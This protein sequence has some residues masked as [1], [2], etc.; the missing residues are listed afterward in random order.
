MAVFSRDRMARGVK[1]LREHVFSPMTSIATALSNKGIGIENLEQPRAP[2]RMDIWIPS[3]SLKYLWDI[4]AG[5]TSTGLERGT[6]HFAVPI[7]LLPL[8]EE[9]NH[10]GTLV[11]A[12]SLPVLEEVMLS[13]DQGAEPGFFKPGL[14]TYEPERGPSNAEITLSILSKTP[15]WLDDDAG[16]DPDAELFSATLPPEA[17]FGEALRFNPQVWDGL[18]IPHN[19]YKTLLVALSADTLGQVF[20]ETRQ[21]YELPSLLISLR[22]SHRLV[23]H[24]ENLQNQADAGATTADTVTVTVPAGNTAIE[25]DGADGVQ[26]NADI[27]DVKLLER[28][29]G[30]QQADGRRPVK[31]HIADD[32]VYHVVV[33]PMLHQTTAWGVRPSVLAYGG[34]NT[35]GLVEGVGWIEEQ[36]IPITWPWEIHHVSA[37]FNYGAPRRAGWQQLTGLGAD[38]KGV[39]P[40][41]ADL[42]VDIGVGLFTGV[43]ADH[44]AWQQV[45]RMNIAFNSLS[46]NTFDRV[47]VTNR[48][49]MT[50]EGFQFELVTIP[51]VGVDGISPKN[52]LGGGGSQGKP[53]QVGR[54]TTR[55]SSRSNID[56]GAPA[57]RG[58]E[59]FL[60]CRWRWWDALG[61][62]LDNVKYTKNGILSGVGGNFLVICGKKPL[63][64]EDGVPGNM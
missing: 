10:T 30:G 5:W 54:G 51:L 52:V 47:R 31:T 26:T 24:G 1:L 13:F 8:Q 41:H 48:Q 6:R 16:W 53:I 17:F 23:P 61:D 29:G 60:C 46:G 34:A 56:G 63:V 64:G 14:G 33:L 38:I 49:D 25:A 22:F 21:D 57:T 62:P 40:T 3:A 9:L 35:P 27:L 43:R 18:A 12:D 58:L 36:Q 2:F 19:P 59:Q 50:D 39:K 15:I 7:P 37:V 11:D 20:S 4:G 28:L 32:S 45:A 44:V 42:N 55:V